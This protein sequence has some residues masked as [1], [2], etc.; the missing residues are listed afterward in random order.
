[1]GREVIQIVKPE[2]PPDILTTR[3]SDATTRLCRKYEAG[4]R[5]FFIDSEIYGDSSV[6]S[7]LI[8]AQ[9]G[10][11]CFCESVIKIDGDVEHFRPKKGSRQDKDALLKKPGYYW[12][13]YNWENLLLCCKPCNSR[14]K[15]N[16][17]PLVDP[18]KRARS[19][20]DQIDD[21]EPLFIH[22]VYD[23]PTQH[24]T[25]DGY[26]IAGLTERG[27]A[28][29]EALGLTLPDRG[30]RGQRQQRF[31]QIE[32]TVQQWQRAKAHGDTET[33]GEAEEM[34]QTYLQPS[35]EFLG[36]TRV[37]LKKYGYPV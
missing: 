37:L 2:T 11:C 4:E 32:L 22:P 10:K 35:E 16:L 36:M 7:A 9:H 1:V 12:L 13:A 25:F 21:E 18:S 34:L 14:Y 27:R 6:K 3:G 17:F 20:G 29:L 33:L 31:K 8:E 28:T 26:D 30:V 15:G 5:D 19:H 23:D 24:I